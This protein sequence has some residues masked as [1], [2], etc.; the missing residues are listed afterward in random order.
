[1][2]CPVDGLVAYPR[3]SPAV[4]VLVERGDQI[5]LARSPHFPPG[6]YS[7]LAGFVV[8]GIE[9]AIHRSNIDRIVDG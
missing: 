8:Q 1:M 6:M 7:T 3:L 9:H 2:K 5:L 4:I